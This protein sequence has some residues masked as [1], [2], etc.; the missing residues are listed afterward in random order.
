MRRRAA[1]VT[2]MILVLGV[3]TDATAADVPLL[4]AHRG[5]ANLWPENSLRAFRNA[6][7]LGADYLETDVHLSADGEVVVI[8]DPTLDRT[9][10]GHGPVRDKR[11]AELAQIRLKARDGTVTDEAVPTLAA[12]LDVLAPSRAQLLLEIKV[13]TDRARYPGIE[14]K[15]L[16]L[17]KARGLTD[18]VVVMAFEPATVRR[19][20]DLDGAIRIA[21]LVSKARLGREGATAPDAVRWTTETGATHL[22]L[23]H[24]AL[25]AAT[26]GAARRAGVAVAV[27]TVNDE[28]AMRRMIDL[29]VDVLITDQPDVALRLLGR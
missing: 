24:S 4:A 13:G 21:L 17:V 3:A 11:L 18:R 26:V 8:H 1:L 14:E 5:G 10:T 29:R 15:A 27:W 7:A 22:G 16:A 23:E 2:A 25:D 20:R 19:V 6:L 12:L 28:V 9:T